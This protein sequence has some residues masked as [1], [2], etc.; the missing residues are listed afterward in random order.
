LYGPAI[1]HIV[2]RSEIRFTRSGP[3][4]LAYQVIGEGP[5]DIVVAI[6]WVSH[7][8]VLWEFPEVAHF[9]D[10]LAGMGRV[11]IFDK[12]G[13]GLSDRPPGVPTYEQMVTDVVAVMDA[14]GIDRAVMVG[15][16]D[17]A[18]LAIY[19]AVLHPDRVRAIVLGETMATAAPDDEHPWG[20]DPAVIE[21]VAEAIET[22]AWGHAILLPLIAPSVAGDERVMAW[23]RRLETM[24]ATP[25]M[26]A[27]ML[28]LT[29]STDVR[30]ILAR[31][32]APALVL[33]R[34][35]A[36]FMPSAGVRWLADHLPDGRYVEVPGDE[37]PGYLGDIDALMDEIEEFLLGTRVG[38]GASRRVVTIMF[39]DVVGST[40]HAADVGDRRWH[41]LLETHRTGMRRLLARYGGAEIDTAGDGFLTTFESPTACIRCA[42]ELAGASR[43]SG[44]SVRIG[45]HAGEVVSRRDGITGLAVH[46][47][48]RIA[49]AADHD[50][51][52]ISQ[53]VRDLV[54]GSGFELESHG[55]HSLKGV[56]GTWELFAVRSELET[57]GDPDGHSDP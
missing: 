27:N 25:S 23:F 18:T 11:V 2:A 7:L 38:A 47:G 41:G 10:R 15:W 17:A 45:I 44:L 34:R 5:L 42:M 22:G 55:R 12:R 21:A 48:A 40:E 37:L 16:V 32:R 54:I 46:I 50:E 53:T 1:A 29:L 35:D 14:A 24:A 9:L 26:A 4:D 20:P 13:T 8:E 56:P 28:R 57:G 49:A 39:S 43:S 3:V 31:V 30:P 6:G 36:P 52:L 19:T 33:H 51:V